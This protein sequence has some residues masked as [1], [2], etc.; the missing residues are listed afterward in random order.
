MSDSP[1]LKYE[2]QMVLIFDGQDGPVTQ[3][4]YDTAGHGSWTRLGG[5]WRELAVE[6][7]SDAFMSRQQIARK[8]W[9]EARDYFDDAFNDKKRTYENEY[10]MWFE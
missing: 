2:D 1:D 9:I 7:E 6:D 3:L 8:N 10:R 4:V 5:R